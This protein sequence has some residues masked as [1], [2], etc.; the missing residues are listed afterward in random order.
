[1][2][3]TQAH[4][5]PKMATLTVIWD[6]LP[7]DFKLKDKPVDNTDQPL[8]AGA[9]RKAFELMAYLKPEMLIASNFGLCATINN[10]LIIKAPD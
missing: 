10:E 8:L 5:V 3:A 1:M 4:P 9:L 2:V 6:K 7:D